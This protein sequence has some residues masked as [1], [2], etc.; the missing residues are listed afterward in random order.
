MTTLTLHFPHWNTMGKVYSCN[1]LYSHITL[2]NVTCCLADILQI[3]FWSK[4]VGVSFCFGG[5]PFFFSCSALN[6]SIDLSEHSQVGTKVVWSKSGMLKLQLAGQIQPVEPFHLAPGAGLV[7]SQS[8][9]LPHTACIPDLAGPGFK[10]HTVPTSHGVGRV[11]CA[12]QF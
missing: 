7:K 1:V 11:L 5:F 6:I 8:R 3:L 4:Y 9:T 2:N 10:L 12:A